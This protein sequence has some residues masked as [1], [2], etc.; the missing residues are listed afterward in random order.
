MT[1]TQPK[2]VVVFGATGTQGGSVAKALLKDP[3]TAQQFKVKAVTRNPSNPAAKALADL[4]DKESL[5]SVLAGAYALFL[6]TSFWDKMDAALEEQQG[7]NVA[8]VAKELNIQHFVWSSLPYVS[9]VSG[10]KYTAAAHFDHKAAVDDYLRSLSLPY[11]VVRLG[12]YTSEIISNFIAPLPIDPPSYGLF[13]PGS[14]SESTLL[15]IIDPNADLGKFVNSILLS[16]EKTIG[17][18]FNVAE[19]LYTL[20]QITQILQQQ[21]LR[22]NL[23][24]IDLQTFKAG[25]AAKGLPESFQTTMQHVL[26]YIVEYGYFHGESIDQALELVTESLT[27]F[28]DAAKA[29]STF[30]QLLKQQ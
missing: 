10:N 8:D 15:P 12:V 2:T 5:K 19:K 24:P 28:E 26:G 7:K 11:T 27:S 9:K 16:P 14:A 6:V 21:G 23:H 20:G 17:H 4:E 3:R 25:L 29:D 13:F 30:N 22:V 1:S 18:S